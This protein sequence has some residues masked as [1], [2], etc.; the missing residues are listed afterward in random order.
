LWEENLDLVC[1]WRFA[2]VDKAQSTQ[3]RTGLS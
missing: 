2:L 1:L 3:V